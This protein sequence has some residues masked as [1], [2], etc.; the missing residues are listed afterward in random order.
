MHGT[1]FGGRGTISQYSFGRENTHND[2]VRLKY[3][4]STS[5]TQIGSDI[6]CIRIISVRII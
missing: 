3:E 4:P 6:H 5:R 1:K 2:S